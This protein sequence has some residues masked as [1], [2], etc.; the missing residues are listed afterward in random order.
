MI[1]WW[2][3]RNECLSV[4]AVRSGAPEVQVDQLLASSV[5]WLWQGERRFGWAYDT[6]NTTQQHIM[7]KV[8]TVHWPWWQW[9]RPLRWLVSHS[10]LL[11][12]DQSLGQAGLTG[13]TEVP[14]AKQMLL[15]YSCRSWSG[16]QLNHHYILLIINVNQRLHLTCST[17]LKLNQW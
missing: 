4:S 3:E 6:D 12:R 15:L 2:R 5:S 10:G 14:A 13:F 8:S 16:Q 9:V 11:P 17:V 1:R 7:F